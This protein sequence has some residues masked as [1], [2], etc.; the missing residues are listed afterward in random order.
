MATESTKN[1]KARSKA[2]NL[3]T[4]TSLAMCSTHQAKPKGL[5]ALREYA[6]NKDILTDDDVIMAWTVSVNS[7][8]RR[9]EALDEKKEQ[10]AKDKRAVTSP[11][12]GRKGGRP[13]NPTHAD[14]AELFVNDKLLKSSCVTMRHHHGSWYEYKGTGWNIISEREVSNDVALFLQL[15][16]ELRHCA[17]KT[18]ISNVV[19]NLRT[20]AFCG[21]HRRFNMPVFLDTG[22]SALNWI[23]FKDK[24]VNVYKYA[25]S[26]A[27]ETT[28]PEQE[29]IKPLTPNF[30][31]TDFV[32]YEWDMSATAPQFFNFLERVQPTVSGFSAVQRMFG[33]MIADTTK[34]EV[35][36][37]LFGNGANGKNVSSD[38][39]TRLIGKHNVS[40]VQL[41]IITERFQSHPLA[42]AKVNICGE[43]PTDIGHG[44]FHHIEGMFKSCVSGEDIEVERK[45]ADKYNSPCRARFILASNSLPTFVDKSDG[46]WRRL[47]IIPY[48]V[49][50]PLH[51]RDT[52]L[53]DNI[54]S[55]ELPGV[56]AWAVEGLAAIIKAGHVADCDAGKILKENHRATCDH[57]REYLLEFYEVGEQYQKVC[58]K[59]L[60]KE[61]CAWILSNGYRPFGAA[62][63]FARVTEIFPASD[64]KVMKVDAVSTRGFMFLKPKSEVLEDD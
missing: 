19:V 22:E 47:R 29:Y 38:V 32:E 18:F 42:S 40:H 2:K 62:K 39:L 53:A 17:T 5:N 3:L 55:S 25:E 35:F 26:I 12:N 52:N 49:Q 34:Y 31:S 24:I 7:F 63:F 41:G 54:I 23:A 8:H 27:N 20:V 64:Y 36:Y 28:L 44:Q 37:Q 9:A 48:E 58:G 13:K 1:D 6:K 16:P 50:I 45:G 21:V 33:L 10:A 43:L 57:E 15:S 61:Y 51:E 60:Y 14:V 59:E 4:A 30:F 46:M 56:M 11:K